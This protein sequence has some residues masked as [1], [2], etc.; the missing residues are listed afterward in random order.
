MLMSLFKLPCDQAYNGEEA[1]K[2]FEEKSYDTILMDINMPVLDGYEA[3]KRIMAI[4]NERGQECSVIGLT[5]Y[6]S[7]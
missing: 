1:V 2:L 7:D 3:T 5:G 6:S 4:A